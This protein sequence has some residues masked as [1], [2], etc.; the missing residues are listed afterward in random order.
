MSYKAKQNFGIVGK[1]FSEGE[2]INE[3]ELGD[4]VDALLDSGLIEPTT[5]KAKEKE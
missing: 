4:A 2:V 3:A 5:K 1:G